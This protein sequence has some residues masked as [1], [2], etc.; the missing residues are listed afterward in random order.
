MKNEIV[1]EGL[2][3]WRYQHRPGGIGHLF[4]GYTTTWWYGWL[5]SSLMLGVGLCPLPPI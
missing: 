3:I 2:N 4:N 1:N 5:I